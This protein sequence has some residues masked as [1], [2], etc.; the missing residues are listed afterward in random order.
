MS[1]IVGIINLDGKPI[2][3]SL[4]SRMTDFMSFRGPDAQQ[5]WIEGNI[6]LGHTLLRTT[7][8]AEYEQ[9][10]FTLDCVTR[11]PCERDICIVADARIDDRETLAEKLGISPL[12]S[13]PFTSESKVITDVELIL[14]AYL[15]WGDDCVQH[16]LGDFA[17]AIWDARHQRLF[18]ARDQFGVKL[19]YYSQVGNCLLISNTLNC[20]RQHPQVSS[21]LNDLAIADFLL[22]EMNQ[23]LTTTTFAD[24]QTLPAASIL[25][26]TP[27]RGTQTAK[28]WTLPLPELIRFKKSQDYL[29]HFQELMGKAVGDR[30][31]RDR[32]SSFFSGGLDSTTIA[33]TAV[34]IAKQKSQ[35]LDLKAFTVVY[36]ELIPDRE[37]YY[38]GLAAQALGMSIDYQVAD[39]DYPYQN[40]GGSKFQTPEPRNQVFRSVSDESFYRG[41][42]HS[43]V[44]LSGN[45][46]DEVFAVTKVVEMFKTMPLQDVL[47]DV[48]QS[49]FKYGIKPHWGSGLLAFLRRESRSS[50]GQ[51]VYPE[52]VNPDFAKRLDLRNRWQQVIDSQ[53]ISLQLPRSRAHSKFDPVILRSFLESHDLE[54]LRVPVETRFPFFDLRLVD[55]LLALPPVPWCVDKMLLRT[56]MKQILPEQVRLRPK[57]PLSEDPLVAKGLDRIDR[58]SLL[59]MSAKIEEYINIDRLL[60]VRDPTSGCDLWQ[61]LVP[62]SIAYW[63]KDYFQTVQELPKFSDPHL[64]NTS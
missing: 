38:A 6:G 41:S 43:R 42:M 54:C 21:E 62:I 8:E 61:H 36:D 57:T 23:D 64:T 44:F 18:C 11:T 4:L 14:R 12:P 30:L 45:G 51:D 59:E 53:Q 63:L 46:G 10:P 15:H 32:V 7:W 50:G 60:A 29:D 19:F 52:W 24:I 39:A 28:Y 49:Y 1:G 34:A 58:R 48:I 33:A 13:P 25:T 2:D 3:P 22:F 37:R 9:Q 27:E 17:F 47:V 31:R 55:Y 5:I 35:P 56:A 16:L 26:H 20:L 40:W